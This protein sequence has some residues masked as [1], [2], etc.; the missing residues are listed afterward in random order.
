M[1]K[2][3]YII[4]VFML[5]I[6]SAITG[7]NCN[8]EETDR[9]RMLRLYDLDQS[10][11][12][13][14]WETPYARSTTRS[15]ATPDGE[16][17]N[18]NDANT[19]IFSAT[20]QLA[21]IVDIEDKSNKV[22]VFQ[23][24]TYFER[25]QDVINACVGAKAYVVYIST[26]DQLKDFA[27]KHLY[28]P[29]NE[30][31]ILVLTNNISYR[32]AESTGNPLDTFGKQDLINLNG[33]TL[34]GQGYSIEGFKFTPNNQ[35][36]YYMNDENDV[37]EGR[38]DSV[39]THSG[40][41]EQEINLK[42]SLLSN[43][44]AVYDLN[45]YVGYQ[46]LDVTPRRGTDTSFDMRMVIDVSPLRNV[47]VIDN[48]DTKGKV[49]MT[50]SV[51]KLEGA[52]ANNSNIIVSAVN[53]SMLSID[54]SHV[55][56][57]DIVEG[58][59]FV[60][61]GSSVEYGDD[62]IYDYDRLI[63]TTVKEVVENEETVINTTYSYGGKITNKSINNCDAY[64]LLDY[65]E[66][67][68]PSMRLNV[69]AL[70]S[71]GNIHA[72]TMSNSVAR[73]YGNINSKG[74]LLL[75][76]ATPAMA[77]HAFLENV[78]A[79]VNVNVNGA[80]SNKVGDED[81]VN[82]S[83]IGGVVGDVAMRSEVKNTTSNMTIEYLA[84]AISQDEEMIL[85]NVS[86][87]GVAGVSKGIMAWNK[88]ISSWKINNAG[89]VSSGA[90]VGTADD[91][92][93]VKNIVSATAEILDG[94]VVYSSTLSGSQIGGMISGNIAEYTA[95]ITASDPEGESSATINNAS[96]GSA[97]PI[98][99][100]LLYF[101]SE[102]FVSVYDTNIES[103]HSDTAYFTDDTLLNYGKYTPAMAKNNVS[104]NTSI[105]YTLP[106]PEDTEV[107]EPDKFLGA[108]INPGGYH[109]YSLVDN[110]KSD[111]VLSNT[112]QAY[113]K[114]DTFLGISNTS[115]LQIRNG[116]DKE[117]TSL[118][119]IDYTT[120]SAGEDSDPIII[121]QD[122]NFYTAN[123]L[124]TVDDFKEKVK[125]LFIGFDK[126]GVKE[127]DMPTE[128]FSIKDIKINNVYPGR[129]LIPD[130]FTDLQ[131]SG[132]N[133]GNGNR[134]GVYADLEIG[135]DEE[136]TKVM[137]Q[138][139]SSEDSANN[140][141]RSDLF[142]DILVMH[143]NHITSANNSYYM[144]DLIVVEDGN[145]HR[146]KTDS[147]GNLMYEE[148]LVQ[149]TGV[150]TA[151][152][153]EGDVADTSIL[154]TNLLFLKSTDAKDKSLY[155]FNK[156]HHTIIPDGYTDKDVDIPSLNPVEIIMLYRLLEIVEVEYVTILPNPHGEAGYYSKLQINVRYENEGGVEDEKPTTTYIL[157]VLH[158]GK[159]DYNCIVMLYK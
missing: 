64:M 45:I 87:G 47:G 128:N 113:E 38:Y 63:T 99:V 11:E 88:T 92:I 152:E 53:V 119:V 31:Y 122:I 46:I 80:C 62:P 145:G 104:D 95:T 105:T 109:I 150:A 112:I 91:A 19:K 143:F 79:D 50:S 144:K 82:A 137:N 107:I 159:D 96:L 94:K 116:G 30:K 154:G 68:D 130:G 138:Y 17:I 23:G 111:N 54:E 142:N 131:M 26:G 24:N 158:D 67:D 72:M 110:Q 51:V 83:V 25:S 120:Q 98:N 100:G 14:D 10:G 127:I 76:G 36:K 106:E 1:K 147:K 37:A 21:G 85:P 39:V 16:V 60:K 151:G 155:V 132:Y 65:T 22:F 117:Y 73:L 20:D 59:E 2:I 135:S 123:N 93:L 15:I 52:S 32:T 149:G 139:L 114:V 126:N 125:N 133:D 156:E 4:A 157:D 41:S 118:F 74:Q 90:L 75:G 70:Q 34:Y 78:T 44:N 89:I 136:L 57:A 40:E 146:Y 29:D 102:N 48:V 5:C 42:Y 134:V 101:Q 35:T 8:N 97:F 77:Q 153:G 33:A 121:S 71:G 148:I 49:A 86:I 12:V 103:I 27:T 108:Y 6:M 56:S 129:Y 81:I 61:P 58:S 3:F 124:L 7:C 66:K 140:L 55:C 84:T 69:G 9:D 13:D 141:H 28:D 43:A 115:K 18:F